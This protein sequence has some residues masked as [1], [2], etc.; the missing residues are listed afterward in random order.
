MYHKCTLPAQKTH[1]LSSAH[2]QGHP[3]HI[4]PPYRPASTAPDP[5]IAAGPP[6]CVQRCGRALQC[7]RRG[8]ATLW[9]RPESV[10][11]RL[12]LSVLPL[13]AGRSQRSGVC[14]RVCACVC[15][16]LSSCNAGMLGRSLCNAQGQRHG[17][18]RASTNVPPGNFS[19]LFV[20]KASL[21]AES[22][23]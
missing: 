21:E 18:T 20:R 1:T 7:S 19:A 10:R 12:R 2:L 15:V 23:G 11:H 9:T 13:R 3:D 16:D 14:L 22:M 8:E 4:R 5:R 17:H 6:A